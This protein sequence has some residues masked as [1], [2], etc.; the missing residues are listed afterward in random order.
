[1]PSKVNK[2]NLKSSA[3]NS[4]LTPETTSQ[5][6]NPDQTMSA[7]AS[8]VAAQQLPRHETQADDSDPDIRAFEA[9]F[10]S[11]NEQDEKAP[12]PPQSK[13]Q[14]MNEGT[15]EDDV[16]LLLESQ[17]FPTEPLNTLQK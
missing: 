2:K 5:D 14:S 9:L 6:Q 3:G 11:S 16:F 1:M 8:S 17:N 7:D 10:E 4:G 12:S 13:D 15:E